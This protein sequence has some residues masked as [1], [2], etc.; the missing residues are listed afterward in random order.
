MLEFEL[1]LELMPKLAIAVTSRS[2]PMQYDSSTR[3][4]VTLQTF[5][6]MGPEHYDSGFINS[7]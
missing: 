6:P 5:V 4:L 1:V 2:L 3:G 7:R